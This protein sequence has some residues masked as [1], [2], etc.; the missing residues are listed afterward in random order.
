MFE[1]QNKKDSCYFSFNCLKE[2][3]QIS[4]SKVGP[5]MLFSGRVCLECHGFD[6][7]TKV[8]KRVVIQEIPSELMEQAGCGD[9]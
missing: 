1:L 8:K 2:V 6:P 3:S 4:K 9:I 5:W 7:C